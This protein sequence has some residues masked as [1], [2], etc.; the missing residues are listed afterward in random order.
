MQQQRRLT[1]LDLGP[2]RQHG[3]GVLQALRHHQVAAH[4]QRLGN[5]CTGQD[6]ATA[7][8]KAKQEC[9]CGGMVRCPLAQRR[10]T[11]DTVAAAAP[12]ML[13]PSIPKG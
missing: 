10:T 9:S 2:Q 3:I 7:A 11:R 6:E 13:A 4:A 5:V 12:A 1:C 8:G